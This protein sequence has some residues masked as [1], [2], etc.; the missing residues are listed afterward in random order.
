LSINRGGSVALGAE[1]L[2]ISAPLLWSNDEVVSAVV[3]VE[4]TDTELIE[5]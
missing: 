4:G 1:E 3:S 2:K 5:L